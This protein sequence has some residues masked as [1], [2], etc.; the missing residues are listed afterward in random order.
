MDSGTQPPLADLARQLLAGH[1]ILLVTHEAPDGD[2][3]GCQ[4]ALRLALRANGRVVTVVTPGEVPAR[5]R[6]LPGA[7]E[8]INWQSLGAGPQEALLREHDLIMVVD[9]HGLEMLGPVGDTLRRAKIPAL[10]LDHHP[11]KGAPDPHIFCN[12]EASSTGEVCWHLLR[13]M[14]AS[15]SADIATCLYTAIT[16]DT[17][18]FKYLR[19]RAETHRVAAELVASG[20]DT[21]EVYRR[22]F[23]SNPPGKVTLTAEL[24]RSFQLEDGGL[25]A[26]VAIPL[27]LVQRTRSEPDDLRDVITYLLEIDGVEIAIT[28]KERHPNLYKVSLRSKGRFAVSGIAAQLGGGGHAFAS[29]ANVDGTLEHVRSRVLR[30]VRELLDQQTGTPA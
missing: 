22:V 29:G 14:P 26:W 21:D 28:F 30:L 11:V 24:L 20:A 19:R 15:M 6:F 8:I 3:I 27:D 9:T 13:E 12:P 2:G 10:F 23:A 4:L 7:A 5:F 17:N 16:Y 25:T 1:R 18:S